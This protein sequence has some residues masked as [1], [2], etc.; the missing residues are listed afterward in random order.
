MGFY[1]YNVIKRAIFYLSEMIVSQLKNGEC[2][3]VLSRT[4]TNKI[5]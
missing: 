4:I 3:S 5:Q 2:Y 1:T